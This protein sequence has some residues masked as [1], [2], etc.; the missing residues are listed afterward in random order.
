MS[1]APAR[2]RPQLKRES[3]GSGTPDVGYSM[4]AKRT[5]DVLVMRAIAAT[6]LSAACA[7]TSLDTDARRAIQASRPAYVAA[8]KRGDAAALA[9]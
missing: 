8:M 3:L 5:R 6:V 2:G 7:Q 1:V 9:R 4:A